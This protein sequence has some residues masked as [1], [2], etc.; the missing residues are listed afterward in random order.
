MEN[1]PNLYDLYLCLPTTVIVTVYFMLCIILILTWK[2]LKTNFDISFGLT[3]RHS[4]RLYNGNWRILSHFAIKWSILYNLELRNCQN[5]KSYQVCSCAT[6]RKFLFSAI[7]RKILWQ[8]R[9][10]C[11]DFSVTKHVIS[12]CKNILVSCLLVFF[13]QV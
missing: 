11:W 7:Y 10:V 2:V 12:S 9:P 6:E 5:K 8:L 1:V 3:N 4:H 13:Y